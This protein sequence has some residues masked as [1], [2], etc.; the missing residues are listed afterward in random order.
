[1]VLGS[2]EVFALKS[3]AKARI[4]HEFRDQP[5]EVVD[6]M[7]RHAAFEELCLCD[8]EGKSG[9]VERFG[10]KKERRCSDEEFAARLK[11]RDPSHVGLPSAH[12][13]DLLRLLLEVDPEVRI[14][15]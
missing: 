2:R 7:L 6:A 4:E 1:M 3:R 5:R 10:E 15:A 13:R 14:T 12:A 9:N 8:S 11:L